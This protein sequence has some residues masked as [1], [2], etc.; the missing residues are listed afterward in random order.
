LQYDEWRAGHG[1]GVGRVAGSV[2][3]LLLTSALC[4]A[5]GFG[6]I[7]S[8]DAAGADQ[9]VMASNTLKSIDNVCQRMTVG[10][11][12]GPMGFIA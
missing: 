7:A 3:E 1:G 10:S 6:L 9:M 8:N 4:A 11:C 12:Q 5:Q 2:G